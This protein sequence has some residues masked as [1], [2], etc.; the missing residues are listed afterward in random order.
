MSYYTVKPQQ[1][2][3]GKT[4]LYSIGEGGHVYS[5]LLIGD[6]SSLL[7][8]TGF[9][10]GDLKGEVKKIIGD[11]PLEVVLSHGHIDHVNGANQFDKAWISPR[12][13]ELALRHSSKTSKQRMVDGL[14]GKY[15]E[16]FDPEAYVHSGIGDLLDLDDNKVFELGGITTSIIPM[17][18]HTAGSVGLLIKEHD[19]L[20]VGDAANGHIWMFLEESLPM[21]V[22]INMLKRMLDVDFKSFYYGHSDKLFAKAEFEK[23]LRAAQTVDISKSNPYPRFPELGGMIYS[24][25]E[26]DVI[27]NPKK[28]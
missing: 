11:M 15:H 13:K 18:G 9:G 23:F 7:Y 16:G 21:S 24:S 27:F 26:A 28:L 12:D 2:L 22:Y 20:L 5:Y 8:D 3:N 19:I 6:T 1:E 10:M 17:E 25:G 14:G 4:W